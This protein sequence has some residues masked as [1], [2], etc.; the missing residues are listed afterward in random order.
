MFL[1]SE[2]WGVY[3]PVAIERVRNALKTQKIERRR[4][5]K[6]CARIRKQRS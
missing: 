5:G 3:T 2:R 6:E 4:G 1:D